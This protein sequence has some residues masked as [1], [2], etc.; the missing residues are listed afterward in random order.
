MTA[1][2]HTKGWR[3][4]AKASAPWVVEEPAEYGLSR[5]VATVASLS[6]AHKIAAAP[7]LMKEGKALLE[8]ADYLAAAY[9]E[10]LL[11]EERE[12]LRAAILKA[13]QGGE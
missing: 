4:N 6:D 13:Q 5:Q 2:P 8:K 3:L 9:A 1:Q 10:P 12:A 7:D 11:F